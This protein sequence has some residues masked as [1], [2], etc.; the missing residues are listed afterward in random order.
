LNYVYRGKEKG[1]RGK[2][3]TGRREKEKREEILGKSWGKIVN[4][5]GIKDRVG[6]WGEKKRKGKG[7]KGDRT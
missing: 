3:G 2:D 5:R 7:T 1:R 4:E 6:E